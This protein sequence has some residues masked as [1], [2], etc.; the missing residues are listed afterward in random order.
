VAYLCAAAGF[1]L[2]AQE[3]PTALAYA[4][5]AIVGAGALGTQLLINDFVAAS[6]PTV[7]RARRSAPRWA[8]G[9]SAERWG[10]S[11]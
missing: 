1:V 3:P 4:L 2:L 9:V 5:V 8:S 6:Y 7:H 10:R 11:T